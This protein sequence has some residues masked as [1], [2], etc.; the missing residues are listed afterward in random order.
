MIGRTDQANHQ[1]DLTD[2]DAA[3]KGGNLPAVSFLKASEY[4]DGH[5]A[6]SDPIDEQHFIVDTIN[7]LQKSKDWSSTAVVIAYDDSD[8]WYDHVAPFISNASTSAAHDVAVCSGSSA[9]VLGGYQDRCGPSQRLP[10]L[11]ISP[12][13]KSNFVAHNETTQPSVLK[14]I[15]DNWKTGRIGDSSFDAT[16]G[17]LDA[18]FQWGRPDGKQVLL[19]ADGSVKSITQTH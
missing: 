19:N 6:Y 17:S 18:M 1:Y 13:A 12:Y 2:F 3:L 15:E 11:V 4:Q 9:P 7:T 14:F 16:A 10:L 8:G 5:A